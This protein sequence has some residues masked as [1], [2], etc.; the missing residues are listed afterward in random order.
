M[1]EAGN[2]LADAA[3]PF[4]REAADQPVDWYPW[5]E[6]AFERAR[7]E[8]KP[9]LLDV[10]AA[11]CH[12][13][14]VMDHESYEDPDTAAIINERFVP[15]KVD[16]DARPDVDRRYQKAV[17]ALTGQGGWP[18][19]AF[20]TPDG[21][22]FY[23]GTYFPPE[24]RGGRPGFPDVLQQVADFYQDQ[25]DEARGRADQLREA[26]GK[27]AGAAGEIDRD[28]VDDAVGS[29]ATQAD[30]AHGGFGSA[31]KFPQT[32]AVDLLLRAAREG[33]DRAREAAVA[34]LEG[35]ARGGIRDH[36]GG[37]FH[38]Y[39]TDDEWTV[40][41]FEKMAYDNAE[42]LR[43]YVHAYQ[44]DGDD[45]W[46]EVAEE[47]ARWIV[48]V[49]GRD[50]GGFA[51]S[52]DADAEPGDDGDYWTWTED[53]IQALLDEDL[54][55][56]V[57]LYHGVGE[58]G[59][60]PHGNSRSVLHVAGDL[61]ALAEARETTVD[62]VEAALE[63]ARER[64]LEARGKRPAPEVD[65]TRYADWNGMLAAALLEAAGPLERPDLAEAALEALDVLDDALWDPDRGYAH[66]LADGE[67][68]G[69][70]TD[71]VHM[72]RAHLAAWQRTGEARHRDRALA[73]ADLLLEA[74]Q[75]DE[76]AGL[77][78]VAPGLRETPDPGPLDEPERPVLDSPDPG[79]NA[80]AA[81]LLDRLA[82]A[83]G[84]D[85]YREAA[86]ALLEAF[87]GL[88]EEAGPSAGTYHLALL[89]HLGPGPT[90]VLAGGTP[91]DR[92]ALREAA[93][94][95]YAPGRVVVDAEDGPVPPAAEA[96]LAG[97]DGGAA[98]FVCLEDRCLAPAE[99][100]EAVREAVDDV[101]A[102]DA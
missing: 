62:E 83:T 53:E 95:A 74:F 20:L 46:R 25:P 38:R 71:H 65:P 17:Q 82:R 54:A 26:L 81:L 22:V 1:S 52:R 79:P 42:I 40:P 39:S 92:D 37:G 36:L 30:L 7:Q 56:L 15:V 75:D 50:E 89:E 24:G 4:L 97:W 76:D 61:E 47:T 8:D 14:H 59:S 80:C 91:E 21:D 102:G 88:T 48:D 9:L 87:A 67:V 23:G 31:P 55:R 63:A 85:R 73:V 44:V 28:R 60:T 41:H 57:T 84:D 13:C 90:V 98:A 5:G 45:L 68:R 12:W 78:D 49:L 29:L 27:P 19:T 3:T 10:G 11:W 86:E 77:R 51:G 18:L 96:P 72:G 66:S 64:L 70:L 34:T 2:R 69:L 16:R 94:E 35:M 58:P 101:V 100:P 43:N 93:L 32:G 99:S 33:T 6:E